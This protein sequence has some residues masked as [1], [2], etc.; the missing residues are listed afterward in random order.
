[1]KNYQNNINLF[2]INFITLI[3][4]TILAIYLFFKP[5]NTY[6]SIDGIVVLENVY[7]IV[8]ND[9]LLKSIQKNNYVYID[10][11]KTHIDIISVTRNYYKNYHQVLIRLK[12]K[13]EKIKVSIF[14][15]ERNFIQLF[16][17]CWEEDK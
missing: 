13:K 12:S 3:A 8:I 5:F 4:T 17:E 14:Y 7:T 6:K 1:M 9:K 15:Q 10:S 2:I 11:K 16:L